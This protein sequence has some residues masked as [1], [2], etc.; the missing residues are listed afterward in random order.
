[1]NAS[2]TPVNQPFLYSMKCIMFF[3]WMWV[4]LL[5]GVIYKVYDEGTEII[6]SYFIRFWPYYL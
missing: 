5:K 2:N 3:I 6:K 1:M 4:K